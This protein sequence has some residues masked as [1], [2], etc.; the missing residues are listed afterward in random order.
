[1]NSIASIALPE[2]SAMQSIG[3]VA[4]LRNITALSLLI[5]KV[6]TRA[7]HLPG[8]GTFSG[9]SGFGKSYAA[10]HAAGQHRAYYVEARSG[11]TKKAMLL[12]ILRQQGVAPGRTITD[13]VDQVAEQLVLSRRPLI[14]DEFDHVVARNLVELVRDIY[15]QS[16]A[17]VIMIGEEF[18]P[19]KLQK[20]ERFH[21][22]VMEW[23]QA[24]PCSLADAQA[25]ARLYCPRV[26]VA[27]D[28]LS[29][30]V[31]DAQGSCRRV[32]V[33]LDRIGAYA[34]D[35]GLPTIT[36]PDWGARELFTGKP[37]ATRSF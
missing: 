33:N 13:M 25:L 29:R 19:Q 9:P 5:T 24:A 27:D 22:R 36:A 32:C 10:A 35:A 21:G 18:L 30:V 11:W 23:M 12:A 15:E 7:T 1:M 17:A 34:R 2:A 26:V 6:M 20:W 8:L 28:L 14:I 4:P 16:A 37:P 3:G 31:T